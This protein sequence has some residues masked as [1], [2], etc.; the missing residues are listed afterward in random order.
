MKQ[1]QEPS[2]QVS[3]RQ[4]FS[5]WCQH[6]LSIVSIISQ[7]QSKWLTFNAAFDCSP[8]M[9]IVK[10]VNRKLL[11]GQGSCPPAA[12]PHTLF[13]HSHSLA[14]SQCCFSHRPAELIAKFVDGELRPG[15]KG[16]TDEELETRMDQALI[17]FRYISVRAQ[18]MGP[19]RSHVAQQCSHSH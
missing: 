16:Q 8:A 7:Q 2:E 1:L 15:N 10:V 9:L 3:L 18:H 6:C 17:L 12:M 11:R 4:G 5:W 14:H 19:S 13:W